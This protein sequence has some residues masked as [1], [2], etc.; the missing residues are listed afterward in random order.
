MNVKFKERIAKYASSLVQNGET[1]YIDSG[2]TTELM[3]KYLKNKRYHYRY[4]KYTNR[5]SAWRY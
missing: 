5:K 4:D 1:I 3:I 2:T